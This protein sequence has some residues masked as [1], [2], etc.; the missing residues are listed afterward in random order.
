MSKHGQRKLVGLHPAAIVLDLNA[1]NAAF[2]Q[3][4]LNRLR[5]G[6][7]GVFDQLFD[8]GRW[9]FN[10]LTSGDL[11]DE[12]VR[13]EGNRGHRRSLACRVQDRLA[14]R[15]SGGLFSR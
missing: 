15:A 12:C 8:H 14:R 6:I 4:D 9:S 11:A 1:T 5:P 3:S 10:H 13:K 2:L 7:D